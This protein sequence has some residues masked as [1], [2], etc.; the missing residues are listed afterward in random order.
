LRLRL[1]LLVLLLLL[2]L[3]GL[4][5][6]NNHHTREVTH[7]VYA[8]A[9]LRGSAREDLALD[10][11]EHHPIPSTCVGKPPPKSPRD[12]LLSECSRF[13]EPKNACRGAGSM[14]AGMCPREK[15]GG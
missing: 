4:R 3:G 6:P 7:L 10:S 5:W 15:Q 13:S 12:A 14:I 2:L 11:G 9:D 8:A 1:R